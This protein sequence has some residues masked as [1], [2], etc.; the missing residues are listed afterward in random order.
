M[1]RSVL[2]ENMLG[3]WKGEGKKLENYDIF[4]ESLLAFQKSSKDAK[5]KLYSDVISRNANKP[6]ILFATINSVI[7]PAQSLY[8]DPYNLSC[9]NFLRFF[10]GKIAALQYTAIT[11]GCI[12]TL[13]L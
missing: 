2:L 6:K 10:N 1:K 4:R 9:E 7:N 11:G 13:N 3:K 5:H 8:P 12:C